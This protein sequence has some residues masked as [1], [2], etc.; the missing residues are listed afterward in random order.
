M[1]DVLQSGYYKSCLGYDNVDW[2]VYEV[3]KLENKKNFSFKYTKKIIIMI[4]E[5][6]ED[7]ENSNI[8]RFCEK[9]LHSDKVRII[10]T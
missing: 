8:C 7:F 4:E 10:V 1:D 6:K 5:N 3:I 9:E 2:F